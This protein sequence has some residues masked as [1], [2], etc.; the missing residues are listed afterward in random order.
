MKSNK[1][2]VFYLLF[3]S[4]KIFSQIEKN[5]Y[6]FDF[7]A[8]II[9]SY[10]P[11]KKIKFKSGCINFSEI[12]FGSFNIDDFR[13]LIN[14]L[15]HF[16]CKNISKD[17]YIPL[18]IEYDEK[19]VKYSSS[20]EVFS[21]NV[22]PKE[23]IV[24]AISAHGLNR[25]L[26][27]LNNLISKIKGNL[28]EFKIVDY[29]LIN[30]RYFHLTQIGKKG[31]TYLKKL[32]SLATDYKF[33]GII[34]QIKRD[35]LFDTFGKNRIKNQF[36][37][38][39]SLI[40]VIN[41]CRARGLKIILE[42]K[43]LTKQDRFYFDKKFLINHETY[44]T[45]NPY[46]YSKLSILFQEIKNDFDVDGIHIGHD[47]LYGYRGSLKK[48]NVLTEDAFFNDIVKLHS[49]IDK[50]DLM[51]F[52]WGDM[53]LSRDSFTR[54]YPKSL[55]GNE[56]M[57]KL[58]YNI[59]KDIVINTFHYWDINFFD[60]LL[61]IYNKGFKVSGGTWCLSENIINQTNYV[62]SNFNFNKRM[63][64]ATTWDG[65]LRHNHSKLIK[66][67]CDLL[68]IDEIIKFTGKTFW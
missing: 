22:T 26:I 29:P 14:T 43:L 59:P 40:D 7:D 65:A 33:N 10:D 57:Q 42:L 67:G 44:N 63:M 8:K 30:E 32:I 24:K 27:Y 38:K 36:L 4:L 6:F 23:I 62:I 46:V 15:D 55:R 17:D 9:K 66:K 20:N 68:E 37:N 51:V 49:L 61:F 19:L 39:A 45:Q 34:L 50:L 5:G 11:Q 52:T 13:L 64:V 18:V 12:N 16:T 47:E 2:V 3:F 56:K 41:Y 21:V 35:V 25:A 31:T 58:L 1:L 48:A 54:M 28:F 53:F 60:S